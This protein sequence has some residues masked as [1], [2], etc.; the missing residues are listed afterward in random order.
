MWYDMYLQSFLIQLQNAFE[1][2]TLYSIR[3]LFD[4]VKKNCILS[5]NP[6]VLMYKCTESKNKKYNW[7]SNK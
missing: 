3:I 6:T 4:E 1:I 7:L 2:C 5:D